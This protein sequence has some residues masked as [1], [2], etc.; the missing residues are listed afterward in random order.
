MNMTTKIKNELTKRFE[1]ANWGTVRITMNK[2]KHMLDLRFYHKYSGK[3]EKRFT[4]SVVDHDDFHTFD[5]I[6]EL[7]AFIENYDVVWTQ[8]REKRINDL[9]ALFTAAI[10]GHKASEI[11][12]GKKLLNRI[13]GMWDRHQNLEDHMI[14]FDYKKLTNKKHDLNT[15]KTLVRLAIDWNYYS[16]EYKSIYGKAIS[17]SEVL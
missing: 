1:D 9:N 6:D 3:D 13:Y 7:A 11:T 8:Q 4:A 14:H 12:A 17:C 2:S 5:S 16:N 10:K 15:V